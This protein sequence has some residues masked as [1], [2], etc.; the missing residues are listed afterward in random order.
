MPDFRGEFQSALN[1]SRETLAQLDQYA[2]L[3]R[4]WNPAINL[5]SKSTI[6]SLWQRHFHDSAQIYRFL[7]EKPCH[8]VDLG[9]GGG[10]PGLILAILAADNRPD[11]KFTLVESDLRKATFLQT[12]IRELR[13]NADV[14]A[15]RIE[16][17]PPLNAGILS[18]RALAPLDKLLE[19]ADT[20]LQPCGI[21]IFPKG[22]KFQKEL[23]Q[24]IAHWHFD[25]EEF[26]SKT[27]P[28][29]AILKIGGISRV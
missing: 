4:K 21:A 29:G 5:V 20:H 19:Y 25:V 2:A 6:E 28:N 15:E 13:L 26:T 24:A 9:S 27:N 12:V 11:A 10:F 22:D 14:M 18:A 8:W 7:P 16:Q 3:L 17:I 23:D 1:V